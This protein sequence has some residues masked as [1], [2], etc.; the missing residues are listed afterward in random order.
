ML[1]TW[2]EKSLV[3]S[4]YRQVEELRQ[5]IDSLFDAGAG[6]EYLERLVVASETN[7]TQAR[8]IKDALVS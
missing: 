5:I 4:C 7:A 6:E 2:I 1:F 8:H 3:T